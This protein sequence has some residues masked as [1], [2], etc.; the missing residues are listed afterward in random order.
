MKRFHFYASLLGL[1]LVAAGACR[2]E[3]DSPLPNTPRMG[4][5]GV[6][7][8]GGS[9]TMGG[10]GGV[11]GGGG[12]VDD[13][14]ETTLDRVNNP[15]HPMAIPVN[16]RVRVKGLVATSKKFLVSQSK[17]SGS[18]LWGFYATTPGD[19]TQ[20]YGSIQV[21]AYGDKAVS[22][23]PGGS[24]GAAGG[25]GAGGTGGGGAENSNDA[26]KDGV[27]NDGNKFT[28]CKDFGCQYYPV[29]G[30]VCS[31]A[32]EA[33]NE[34]CGDGLDNDGDG[35]T[36]CKDFS[37]YKSPLVTVCGGAGG[38][39]G[40]GGSGGGE[41]TDELCSDGVSND[42]DKYIDCDDFDC[43]QNPNVTVCGT[44]GGGGALRCPTEPGKAGPIPDDIEPGK[45]VDVVGYVNQFK[46]ANCGMDT[47]P[48]L[49][50]G[51]HQLGNA[52]VSVVGTGAVPAP[53][54]FTTLAEINRLGTSTTAS[55]VFDKWGGGLVRISGSGE[56][57][58]AGFTVDT[59]KIPE[60]SSCAAYRGDIFLKETPL[61]V[62]SNIH[63][64]DLTEGG[65]GDPTDKKRFEYPAGTVFTSFQGIYTV[66]FC[67]WSVS[68][69]NAKG[70]EV[71]P[72][73]TASCFT[74][75]S[76]APPGAEQ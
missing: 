48:V 55:D 39:A 34:Q 50:V 40:A 59:T 64:N 19:A 71:Q 74:Q 52:E 53:K 45:L 26:C 49:A 68:V 57:A 66:D 6:S 62:N 32:G 42:G 14:I 3:D 69:R 33:T 21:V 16:A 5:S 51:Q 17:S 63:F 29:T 20:E 18:C 54:E 43:S 28:D 36:D 65:P 4:S 58:F 10:S 24:G 25:A 76:G 30:D 7:G 9:G 2:S 60:G 15:A 41:N 46:L 11:G 38:G 23:G 75:P 47:N 13:A 37:C 61:A 8:A 35:F 73:L 56:L 27:D 1:G 12:G 22:V 31:Q 72:P 44:P 67:S 70:D